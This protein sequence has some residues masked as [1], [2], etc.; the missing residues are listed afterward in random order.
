MD[1]FNVTYWLTGTRV[2]EN[3]KRIVDSEEKSG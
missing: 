3:G 1:P 2:D